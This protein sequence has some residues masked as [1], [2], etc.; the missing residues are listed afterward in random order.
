MATGPRG[1]ILA[2]R[3][4]DP[5]ASSLARAASLRNAATKLLLGVLTGSALALGVGLAA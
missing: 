5:G 2:R 4:H 3:N 1:R